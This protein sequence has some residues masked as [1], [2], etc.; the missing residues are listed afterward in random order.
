M[1]S[2]ATASAPRYITDA[3]CSRCVSRFTLSPGAALRVPRD[4]TAAAPR[5]T[6]DA[7]CCCRHRRRCGCTIAWD[8]SAPITHRHHRSP[9]I[10]VVSFRRLA[11][12]H[13]LPIMNHRLHHLLPEVPRHLRV[14]PLPYYSCIRIVPPSSVSMHPAHRPRR[15]VRSR[16]PYFILEPT[17]LPPEAAAS[18]CCTAPALAAPHPSTQLA[19]DACFPYLELD[20]LL[21]THCVGTFASWLPQVA[22]RG[23]RPRVPEA[24]R[25]EQRLLLWMVHAG[26]SAPGV[27]GARAPC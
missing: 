12:A 23:Q 7:R 22:A 1:P 11:S 5:Y 8:C 18:C 26:A 13:I 4:A 2:D 19:R 25:Q 14:P 10:M 9:P 16:V 27:L 21:T 3:R 24:R 20:E 6:T 17:P 15:L